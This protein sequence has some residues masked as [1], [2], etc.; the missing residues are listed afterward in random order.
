VR[1]SF[2]FVKKKETAL[3]LSVPLFRMISF[4]I[5]ERSA[6]RSASPA[7][8]DSS[9]ADGFQLVDLVRLRARI[10]SSSSKPEE[11]CVFSA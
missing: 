3:S 2:S 5:V 9:H 4:I 6:V 1:F 11:S 7:L 8:P 10:S